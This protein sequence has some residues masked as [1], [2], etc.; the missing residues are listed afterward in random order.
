MSADDTVSAYI[1]DTQ[2][3]LFEDARHDLQLSIV[4]IARQAKLPVQTVNAWAQGRNALSLWGVKKLLRVEKLAPLLS[5]LFM[6]E[7]C[8]LVV[9]PAGI[10]LDSLADEFADFLKTKN[11]FHHPDSE[12]GRDLGPGE[13]ALLNAKVI[14][15][16]LKVA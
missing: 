8:A 15:L 9:I 11:D 3:Q 13:Q 10:D 5:R 12:C 2:I 7:G 4:E 14:Q 1:L 6:P 16:P